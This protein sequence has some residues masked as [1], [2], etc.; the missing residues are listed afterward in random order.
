VCSGAGLIN[1]YRGQDFHNP[2]YAVPMREVVSQV[3]HDSQP[4]DIIIAEP[5]TAFKYYYRRTNI[6]VP[7]FQN[8]ESPESW[9]G[10]FPRRIWLVTFG[11]DATR[12]VTNVALQAWLEKNYHHTWDQGYVAQDPIYMKIKERLLHRPAYAYKLLVQRYEYPQVGTQ[13]Q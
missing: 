3:I 1:Y 4:G 8:T 10:Q 11:R 5:D 6:P 9:Q 2:I 12:A 13:Q 7:V